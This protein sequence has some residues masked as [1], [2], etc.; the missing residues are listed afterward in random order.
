[1]EAILNGGQIPMNEFLT[2]KLSEHHPLHMFLS[3]L[4]Q[5]LQIYFFWHKLAYFF[6]LA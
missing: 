6:F 1:M 3:E 4:V 2:I 5:I